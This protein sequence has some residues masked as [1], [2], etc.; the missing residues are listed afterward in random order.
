MNIKL[1]MRGFS[2]I[3][4]M[5]ALVILAVGIL[6]ISKLQ[7]TLIRNSSDANQRAVA[8]SLA[9]KKI[10]D[11]KSFA[12][13]TVGTTS[14]AV[15]DAWA[16][17]G[18]IAATNLSFEHIANS[19]GGAMCPSGLDAADA[20]IVAVRC[21]D[22]ADLLEIANYAYSID[23]DVTDYYYTGSPAI[24][25]TPVPAGT[26]ADFKRVTLHVA[27]TDEVGD[28]QSIEL[29]TVIDS[30][31][32][33]LTAL[34]NNSSTGGIPP[35]ASYL[36]EAAPDV[37]DITVDTG[38]GTKRQ[39]SKPLPDAVKTGSD[40]NTLV[41]FEVISYH[42]DPDDSSEF[43]ADRQEEFMT[44]D[45]TCV[46]SAS[47]A[48]A[49]PPG[50][51]VWDEGD[52]DRYDFVGTPISKAT[53]TQT[54]NANA[55]DAVCTV[56]CRDHHDDTASVVKY[57]AGTATGDHAH[58]KAD[59]TVAASG[60][61]YIESCR[62]KRINGVMR[63][64][65]DW[66]LLDL[67]VMNRDDLHDGDPLQIQYTAYV[68]Q[69]LK[70]QAESTALATKPPLRTPLAQDTDEITQLESRGV[71]IDNVYNVSTGALSSEYAS[72]IADSS[73]LDRLER[74]PFAEVNLSLLSLWSSANSA[75]VSVRNDPVATVADSDTDYYGVYSRGRITSNAAAASP[76]ID[77]TSIMDPGNDGITQISINP[78]PATPKTDAI[79]VVVS[80]V[81][82]SD[83]TVTG[84]ADL[85][86]AAGTPSARITMETEECVF[87]PAPNNTDF[88]CTFT[89]GT[90]VVITINL[91]QGSCNVD[92]V[93]TRPNVSSDI[94]GITIT[95]TCP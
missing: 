45:C 74:I 60:D 26:D 57:V 43:F 53:A 86:F 48:V 39:T 47:P 81:V 30:Y 91:K 46:L 18:A 33:A 6:G 19:Q 21:P 35:Q 14:D 28:D 15:P 55:V 61:E 8:V 89:S 23:W 36:P 16:G 7:S 77:I 64:F 71:Y 90:D 94:S 66:N 44:V 50:H 95:A 75:T 42:V 1:T 37:I 20:A 88:T 93:F 69:L 34:A 17:V 87:D 78:S 40:A 70:D 82:S 25:T 58:Y 92:G 10:D 72:Y 79:A 68:T 76:G 85:T 24:A 59:S 12:K 49:Y 3:E 73:N 80:G 9:Q 13:L 83:I 84:T 38:A 63:I 11:L 52:E 29:D 4:V 54:G 22:A 2:L 56:C 32:P 5:V 31:A 27:W 67:T 62:F 41:T 51:V 65:Q